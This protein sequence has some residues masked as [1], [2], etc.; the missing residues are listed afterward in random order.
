[1]QTFP[2]AEGELFPGAV[3]LLMALV[4]IF[5]WRDTRD[6]HQATG[7]ARS[8]HWIVVVLVVTAIVHTVAAVVVLL[9]RRVTVDLGLFTLRMTDV[10]QLLLRAAI[11]FGTALVLSPGMRARTAAFMQSRGFFLVALVTAA[12]LS[13]GPVPEALGRPVNLA[14]PYR[15]LF[16]YVPGFGG[17]RA[18]ARFAMVVVLMLTTL[19]GFGAAV[20]ARNRSGR[21]ML[22]VLA[23]AFLLEATRV[24]FLMNGMTPT[25]RYNLPEARLYR[26][27]RAPAIYKEV[28]TRAPSSVLVELPL[29]YPD[30]DL[31]AMYYSVAHHRPLLNGYS[32]F[33]SSEYVNLTYA[34]DELPRHP[35]LSLDA[36]RARGATH[37][38]VHE[39]AFLGS[40][41]PETTA[42]L[43]RLGASELFRDGPD[44][45]LLLPFR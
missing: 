29:G 24:P 11:A 1:M 37:A 34:I 16:D 28:A 44:V 17:L 7:V 23:G 25:P 38:I 40:E 31:R 27:A 41:G 2:K 45:L 8:P 6:S 21:V 35:Q 19:A 18:P 15:L 30:F 5:V 26:P 42:A 39:S 12:W 36:M 3:P 32:G 14:S 33:F 13:L 4:G 10:S 43:T 9:I 20:L 22:A